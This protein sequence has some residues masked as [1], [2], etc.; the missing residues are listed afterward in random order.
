MLCL[1]V[2]KVGRS[3][4]ALWELEFLSVQ[5]PHPQSWGLEQVTIRGV[6]E[7]ESTCET[8]GV[9]LFVFQGVNFA[10]I[11]LPVV[12][13][14]WNLLSA[15]WWTDFAY[16]VRYVL[17]FPKNVLVTV[18]HCLHFKVFSGQGY[19]LMSLPQHLVQLTDYK[20]PEIV[21]W[22]SKYWSIIGWE[23]ILASSLNRCWEKEP[24]I[25]CPGCQGWVQCLQLRNKTNSRPKRFWNPKQTP[26]G[27]TGSQYDSPEPRQCLT[28]VD[29]GPLWDETPWGAQVLWGVI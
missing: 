23:W 12:L 20:P 14:N 25:S 1:Q 11:F 18:N 24:G 17:A 5:T 26:G 9:A 21:C 7:H 4:V 16:Q 13:L 19:G 3:G 15:I 22:K 6:I 10:F 28:V 8:E 29:S 2:I 27:H